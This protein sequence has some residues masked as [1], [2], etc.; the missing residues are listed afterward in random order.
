MIP[1][2]EPACRHVRKENKISFACKLHAPPAL[3]APYGLSF[4]WDRGLKFVI[5][6]G[7][8][9]PFFAA[10]VSHFSFSS[11]WEDE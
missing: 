6:G 10:G 2:C 1:A 8:V 4:D 9:V 11:L 3:R 7:R 5:L